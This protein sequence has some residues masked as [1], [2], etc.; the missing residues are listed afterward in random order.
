MELLSEFQK[1]KGDINYFSKKYCYIQHSKE[2]KIL[3]DLYPYQ[4]SILKLF[5]NHNKI[6]IN[7]SRQIGITTT[8]CLYILHKVLFNDDFNVYISSFRNDSNKT[9]LNIISFMLE[10]ISNEFLLE[11]QNM[12]VIYKNDNSIRFKNGCSINTFDVKYPVLNF[13]NPN[14]IIFDNNFH[15]KDFEP[16]F[17]S[18]LIYD[19]CQIL[20]CATPLINFQYFDELWTNAETG[21]NGF[22]PIKL[23]WDVHPKRDI[24]WKLEQ[25]RIIGEKFFQREYQCEFV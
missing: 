19:N 24:K 3:F 5:P 9:I 18:T 1:C 25:I 2:G 14:L 15:I 22:L 4:E 21:E 11:K 6:I 7:Q 23:K 8:L 13:R 17:K 20:A 12:A 10:N 16:V